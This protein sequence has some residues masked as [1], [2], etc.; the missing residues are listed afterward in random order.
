MEENHLW[1]G[2]CGIS[3]QQNEHF[4]VK[5]S[6]RILCALGMVESV[7]EKICFQLEISRSQ[8]DFR[9]S[10]FLPPTCWITD[11]QFAIQTISTTSISIS[12]TDYVDFNIVW[13]DLKHFVWYFCLFNKHRKPTG[14]FEI[15]DAIDEIF[16][17]PEIKGVSLETKHVHSVLNLFQL[18]N[19]RHYGG[20][21]T[22]LW[23]CRLR[24]FILRML[25]LILA[26]GKKEKFRG[27]CFSLNFIKYSLARMDFHPELLTSS[28][29]EHSMLEF[30]ESLMQG[31]FSICA[32]NKA[33]HG[34]RAI[35][36]IITMKGGRKTS[37]E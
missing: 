14:E 35:R 25:L 22:S 9:S 13:I 27:G 2:I 18:L 24:F 17:A 16:E 8:A 26:D 33:Q 20:E 5:T 29:F 6:E 31:M 28:L 4:W 32:I 23:T 36:H 12:F 7:G 34:G 30:L 21:L 37:G 19:N 15:S 11:K 10:Y 3:E 1:N